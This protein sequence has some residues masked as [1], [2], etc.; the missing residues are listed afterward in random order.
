MG[1][2]FSSNHLRIDVKILPG[3]TWTWA[4]ITAGR[5]AG[6]LAPSRSSNEGIFGLNIAKP[7]CLSSLLETY[8]DESLI[9]VFVLPGG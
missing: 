4:S 8:S 1:Q 3:K 7:A 9:L 6:I 5:P 2:A